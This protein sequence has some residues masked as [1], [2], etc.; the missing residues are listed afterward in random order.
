MLVRHKG[1]GERYALKAI[2]KASIGNSKTVRY[3]LT[4]KTV[5][6]TVKSPYIVEL[7]ATFQNPSHLF[8]LM[9][10]CEGGDLL[11]MLNKARRF[12]EERARFY[13]ACVIEGLD[14]LH[15]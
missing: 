12:S 14:S 5:M 13:A 3:I 8:F 7:H 10:F 4:E 11:Q 15:R 1:T 6:L 9:E 2:A